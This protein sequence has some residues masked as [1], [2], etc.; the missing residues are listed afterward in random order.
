MGERKELQR[1]VAAHTTSVRD[2]NRAKIVLLAA[3]GMPSRQISKVVAMHESNVA[4]WRRR[5]SEYRVGGLIDAP[6]P[7]RPRIY[8]H[9]EDMKMAAAATSERTKGDPISTWSYA[10]LVEHLR[11]TE[12][13]T[14][15]ASQL[16]RILTTMEVRLDWVRVG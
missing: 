8:G 14:A 16:W 6:R 5:F 4:K 2:A 13:I 9:K 11:T 15:S 3:D 7:G 1:R 10:K 12:G